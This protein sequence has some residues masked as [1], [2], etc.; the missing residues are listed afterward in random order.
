MDKL[1]N[2]CKILFLVGLTYYCLL[3]ILS[4]NFL[5]EN[6]IVQIFNSRFPNPEFNIF[7]LLVAIY[8]ISIYFGFNVKLETKGINISV[9]R[10][11]YYFI[12]LFFFISFILIINLNEI[13]FPAGYTDGY[14]IAHRGQLTTLYLM[15]VWWYIFFD[16]KSF[17]KGYKYFFIILILISGIN[18]LF[19][20]SRLGFLT[21][22]IALVV[23]LYIKTA[24]SIFKFI[25]VS[26]SIIL[27]FML[28]ILVGV[29]RDGS[30]IS[31]DGF[32]N[33]FQAESIFIY[34]SIPA[35]L[36]GEEL[37]L[38]NEPIDLVATL[39]GFIPSS[40]FLNKFELMDLYSAISSDRSSGMGGGNHIIILLANFGIIFMPLMGLLEGLFLKSVIASSIYSKFNF[41]NCILIISLLPFI[42]F[43]EGMQTPLKLICLNFTFLPYILLK[44]NNIFSK[45]YVY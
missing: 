33:I 16:D 1:S 32:L 14:D 20:G 23:N 35:Y 26:T 11:N 7:I 5:Y 4:I 8:C 17:F 15:C 6:S 40:L 2:I 19:L 22:I 24:F 30:N 9:N 36:N 31:L 25:Y 28:V 3:P 38:I 42:W 37:P 41:T 21:G 29:V 18:L 10:T 12:V 45:K 39:I 44:I 27:I 34:M 43:R 13:L